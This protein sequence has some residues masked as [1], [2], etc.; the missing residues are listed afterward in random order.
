FRARSTPTR[1][2]APLCLSEGLRWGKAEEVRRGW[3]PTA[4]LRLV[5]PR[6]PSPAGSGVADPLAPDEVVQPVAVHRQLEVVA[7]GEAVAGRGLVRRAAGE[8]REP[9][10][11]APRVAVVRG[12]PVPGVPRR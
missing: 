8:V 1:E 9:H 4:I 2:Y 6:V 10:R 7:V 5:A 11:R 12:P 3:S